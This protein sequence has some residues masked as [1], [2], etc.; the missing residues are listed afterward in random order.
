MRQAFGTLDSA[1]KKFDANFDL[2][3]GGRGLP[4]SSGEPRGHSQRH[5]EGLGCVVPA[6]NRVPTVQTILENR[7]VITT[8]TKSVSA[9]NSNDAKLLEQTQQL[10]SALRDSGASS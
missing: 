9:I 4:S 7:Q 3:N 6:N 10:V 5:Q 1:Y 8:V 2:V